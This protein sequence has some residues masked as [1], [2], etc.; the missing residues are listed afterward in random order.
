MNW[1]IE[2]ISKDII[3]VRRAFILEKYFE[4]ADESENEE[5]PWKINEFNLNYVSFIQKDIRL[6]IVP[7]MYLKKKMKKEFWNY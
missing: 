6:K 2:Q 3:S 7:E 1:L 5:L 4:K